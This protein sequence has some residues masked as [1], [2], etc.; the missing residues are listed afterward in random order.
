MSWLIGKT[1]LQ[2]KE[3]FGSA[4]SNFYLHPATIPL[5]GCLDA[6]HLVLILTQLV[7]RVDQIQAAFHLE[8]AGSVYSMWR[9][10]GKDLAITL[11]QY[12]KLYNFDWISAI[13]ATPSTP[14]L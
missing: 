3:K 6:C 12:E 13:P 11:T 14:V 4:I 7:Y 9:F 8:F 1:V 10:N 2:G 5:A